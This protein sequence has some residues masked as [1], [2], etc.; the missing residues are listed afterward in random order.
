MIISTAHGANFHVEEQ[1]ALDAGVLKHGQY[2]DWLVRHDLLP[3]SPHSVIFD[4]G[5]NAG[6]C[7]LPFAVRQA[8]CAHVYSYE[9][10]SENFKKLERNIEANNKQLSGRIT[11]RRV[12]L[13]GPDIG[14][15]VNF[16]ARRLFD[17]DG[18]VNTG[19]SSLNPG[20]LP[21]LSVEIV[22]AS[23]VDKEVQKYSL[24]RLDLLKIDTEGNEFDVL[25]GATHTLTE[26]H[27]RP[28]LIWEASWVV[29]MRL[30]S[31]Y[32]R[33]CFELLDASGYC[34]YPIDYPGFNPHELIRATNFTDLSQIS[35][36]LNVLSLPIEKIPFMRS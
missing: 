33:D 25:R 32:V 7:S 16:F 22:E 19:L 18:N 6:Y 1:D 27:L 26:K 31:T 3:L 14:S 12:A 2:N 36:D 20:G 17:G 4:V 28:F 34:H 11:P 15:T 5:A 9:P 23:T 8:R 30:N 29:Q 21:H 35:A 24:T 13:G 10:D